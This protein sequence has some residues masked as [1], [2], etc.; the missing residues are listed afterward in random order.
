MRKFLLSM[1][2][3]VVALAANAQGINAKKFNGKLEKAVPV[4][5]APMLRKAPLTRRA[6]LAANQRLIGYY[7]TDD[8]DNCLGLGSMT[9][10]T[11]SAGALLEPSDYSDYIG[12]KVVGIRFSMGP[13]T[14]AS[15]V[16]VYSVN[17]QGQMTSIASVDTTIV[18]SSTM[19]RTSVNMTWN[20]VMFPESQQFDLTNDFAG[21]MATYT[22]NQT[23]SNYP[24]GTYSRV[25]NRNLYAYA[26]I[27]A[28]YGG[29]GEGWYN[30]GGDYG[31]PAI[32]L[33]VEGEFPANDLKLVYFAP[34]VDFYQQGT[35]GQFAVIVKNTGMAKAK[36]E[37]AFALD[38]TPIDTLTNDDAEGEA[39][40]LDVMANDTI[41]VDF[42][43]DEALATGNHD[44]K[45]NVVSINGEAPAAE[46]TDDDTLSTSFTVYKDKADRQKNLV[47]HYTSNECTFCYLGEEFLEALSKQT[48]KMAWVSVHGIQNGSV[49][50]PTRTAQCDTLMAYGNL[51]GFPSASFDRVILDGDSYIMGIGYSEQ[52]HSQL[53]TSFAQ[54]MD[55]IGEM[56]PSF[57]TLGI[58]N[59]FDNARNLTVTVT[60]TGVADAQKLIGDYRL[61]VYL[62][63]DSLK[64]NQYT[65]GRWIANDNHN[66]VFRVALGTVMGNAINWNGDNFDATYTYDIPEAWN[67]KNMKVVAFV[68]PRLDVDDLSRAAVNQ[69]AESSLATVTGIESV[70][71]NTNA[72]AN[73]SVSAIYN[74]AG[75]RVAKAQRGLNI[76]KYADGRTEK[77]VV[78]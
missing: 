36:Y 70:K 12:K 33:I 34:G 3:F 19:S 30:F 24:I 16:A 65:N 67:T 75:Q 13:S 57:V 18:S 6:D 66:H 68:A 52:Y 76:V 7:T 56:Y 46:T 59:S 50:D 32:Q 58:N 20:T 60:G 41:V 21:L 61:Y 71:D 31:A 17:S 8:A 77:V 37:L 10:G 22:Y 53:A 43:V 73:N 23:A 44:L 45:V 72:A 11:N 38:G 27:S 15:N 48:D 47:E 14:T 42:D 49:P 64:F 25:T 74:A 40:S 69:C 4:Q 39:D 2:A 51:S 62:C 28:T 5:V 29:S 63:E 55:E 54:I 9:T 26:N 78:K 1:A 35:E